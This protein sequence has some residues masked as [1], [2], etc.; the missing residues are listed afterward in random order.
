MIWSSGGFGVVGFFVRGCVALL[1]GNVSAVAQPQGV[2]PAQHASPLAEEVA[3]GDAWWLG[4]AFARE[5]G[6]CDT[7][8]GRG[9]S[10][11]PLYRDR[12]V[13]VLQR[14]DFETLASGM[15]AVFVGD[16]GRLVA[17]ML[18]EK[19]PRGWLAQGVGNRARDLTP[20]KLQNYVGIVIKAFAPNPKIASVRT[21]VLP[22]ANSGPTIAMRGFRPSPEGLLALAPMRAE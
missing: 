14:V 20:V 17:H 19:T 4:E 2:A 21:R 15:T 13:L 22:V 10:M 6:D 9:D 11:L 3:P 5:R 16:S 8:V 1:C 7:V 18:M 12:T